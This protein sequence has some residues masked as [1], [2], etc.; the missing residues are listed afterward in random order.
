MF[1]NFILYKKKLWPNRS[2]IN[3]KLIYIF[4][5][6][7]ILFLIN[8]YINSLKSQSNYTFNLINDFT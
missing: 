2:L 8:R 1:Q 5:Y 3:M 6:N 7:K 4:I